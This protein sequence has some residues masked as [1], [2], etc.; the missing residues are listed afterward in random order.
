VLDDAESTSEPRHRFT[1]WLKDF[2][3]HCTEA[4]MSIRNFLKAEVKRRIADSAGNR[5]VEV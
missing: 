5:N 4:W 3:A 2:G 1:S